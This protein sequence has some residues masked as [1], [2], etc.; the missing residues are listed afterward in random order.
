MPTLADFEAGRDRTIAVAQGLLAV[1]DDTA[2]VVAKALKGDWAGT[3]D[4]R[5]YSDDSRETLPTLMQSD[6]AMLSWTFDDGPGK[7]VRSS[8]TWVFDATGQALTI[9]AGKN[10]PDHW[11][12]LEAHTS[13]DGASLTIVLE[14][15]STEN[16][17]SVIARKVLTRDGNRLRMT[18]QTRVSGEPFLMRQ[19]YELRQ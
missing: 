8:E 1:P 9:T 17:R 3:L 10:A 2:A 4:Y 7:T 18:K 12:V 6:G 5:D 11:R 19:S 14:G 15:E 13:A 16:G